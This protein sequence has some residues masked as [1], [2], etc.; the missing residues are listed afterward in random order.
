MAKKSKPFRL[1]G[2]Q[3]GKGYPV[4][5][6]HPFP[7]TS[8]SWQHQTRALSRFCRVICPDLPGFGK[9]P[10]LE[11]PTIAGMARAV[12]DDLKRRGI[13]PPFFVAGLSMG[14][15]VA[16]EFVRQFPEQVRGFALMG[17]RAGAD[18]KEQKKKRHAL[19]AQVRNEGLAGIAA[20]VLPKLVT[21]K[22]QKKNPRGMRT[23]STM[24]QASRP[25]GVADALVAMAGRRDLNSLLSKIKCPALILAGTADAVIPV[26]ESEAMHAAIPLGRLRLVEGAGHLFNLE[27]PAVVNQCLIPFIRA[28]METK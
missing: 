14:G 7:L 4:V 8:A 28:V 22:Y 5:L 13:K 15:Y 24:L 21:K 26:S 6:I 3:K 17:T 25:D 18:T 27:Q 2:V 20:G 10:R 16:L 12:A 9:S 1:H 19:A 11:K 23:L